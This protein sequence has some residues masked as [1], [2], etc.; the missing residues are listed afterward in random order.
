V[1]VGS[2]GSEL[3]DGGDDVV[4]EVVDDA[5]VTVDEVAGGVVLDDGEVVDDPVTSAVD[6]VVVADVGL[7]GDVHPAGGAVAP[8][9]PGMST[10]PAQPKFENS[11]SLVMVVPSTK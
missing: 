2:E 5:G 3:V 1:L 6:V 11:A 9:W 10:V 4:V 7:S 8:V